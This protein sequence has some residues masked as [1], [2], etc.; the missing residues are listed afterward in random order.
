ML[1]AEQSGTP[2]ILSD[3]DIAETLASFQ[4]YGVRN[5]DP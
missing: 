2:V 1:L 4:G 5:T 3:A